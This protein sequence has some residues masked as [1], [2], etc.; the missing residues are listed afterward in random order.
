VAYRQIAADEALVARLAKTHAVWLDN[1]VLSGAID[2]AT[3]VLL[4][5]RA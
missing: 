1:G 5:G 2:F 4:D 3:K